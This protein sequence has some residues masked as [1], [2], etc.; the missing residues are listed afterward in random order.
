MMTSPFKNVP[1]GDLLGEYSLSLVLLVLTLVVL[2]II[3]G[4]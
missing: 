1:A 4:M 3:K 2:N